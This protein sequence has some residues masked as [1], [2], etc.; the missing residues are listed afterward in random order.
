MSKS[1]E[2]WLKRQRGDPFVRDAVRAG[3][4]SRAAFKLAEIDK[5]HRLFRPGMRICDLGAAP[6]SFSQY[7]AERVGAAGLVVAVDLLPMPAI[8]GVDFI[9]GDFRDD[10]VVQSVHVALQ[11]H[12]DL[13]I[14]DMAPNLSGNRIRDQADCLE[15][16]EAALKLA[17]ELLRPDGALLVKLFQG[18]G[19]EE[20]FAALRHEF[21]R[22][23]WLKPKASR[24]ESREVYALGVGRKRPT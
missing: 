2:R 20:W 22:A 19:T 15:L 7:A 12:A 13:V 3:Y 9:Q 4:R 18:E 24:D 10:A 5:R 8:T 17:C 23:H 14:S 21:N 1:S 6:G 16:A 11:G